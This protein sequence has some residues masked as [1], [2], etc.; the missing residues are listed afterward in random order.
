MSNRMRQQGMK[1]VSAS[2]IS[3]PDHSAD[4]FAGHGVRA[5]FAASFPNVMETP[6]RRHHYR[7]VLVND[8]ADASAEVAD[9]RQCCQFSEGCGGC[10]TLFSVLDMERKKTPA[11]AK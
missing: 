3:D 10:R 4:R 7:G 11:P 9:Q 2:S 6:D 1:L 5:V 8:R